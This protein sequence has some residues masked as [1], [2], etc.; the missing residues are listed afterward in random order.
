NIWKR[1]SMR[2]SKN[3][4]KFNKMFTLSP[5][6]RAPANTKKEMT[7]ATSAVPALSPES[8]ADTE[9]ATPPASQPAADQAEDRQAAARKGKKA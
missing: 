7:T 2:V 9:P 4:V 8:S 1:Y 6:P 5:W 3:W